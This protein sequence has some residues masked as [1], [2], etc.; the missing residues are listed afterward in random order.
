M[1]DND[2]VLTKMFF[3]NV[4]INA[5]IKDSKDNNF[6]LDLLLSLFVNEDVF[7]LGMFRGQF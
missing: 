6:T 7:L 3:R 1:M 4:A 5:F 2:K